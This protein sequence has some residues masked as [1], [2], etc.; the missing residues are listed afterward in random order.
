MPQAAADNAPDSLETDATGNRS[1]VT[2]RPESGCIIGKGK[3]QR[4]NGLR[5]TPTLPATLPR[6]PGPC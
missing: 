5:V 3:S 2:H 6:F 4:L 1:Y